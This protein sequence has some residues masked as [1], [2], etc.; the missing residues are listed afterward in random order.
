MEQTVEKLRS[1]VTYL[2]VILL[3]YRFIYFSEPSAD[4]L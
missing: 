1:I 4:N 3:K 2:K